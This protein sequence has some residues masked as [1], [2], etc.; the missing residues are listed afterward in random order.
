MQEESAQIQATTVADPSIDPLVQQELDDLASRISEKVLP[1]ELRFKIERML[2]HLRRAAHS[3][4]Y[5]EEYERTAKYIEWALAVPWQEKSEDVLDLERAK[6]VFEEHHYG[7]Q[8]IKDRI[9]EYMAILQ[10]QKQSVAAGKADSVRA[11]ILLLVGLVGTGKTTFA[12]SIAEA[13]GREIIRVPFGGMGSARDLRGQSRLHLEAEPGLVIKGL[14][15]AKTRNPVM[16]LDEIDRVSE[17]ARMD[18]MGVLV[19]LLD[20][21][22]NH[23]FTDHY[24]DF[25]VDLSEVLFI[26][27]ANNTRHIATAVYDRMEHLTM[28]SYT[29]E[30]K[31]HIARRYVMPKMLAEAGMNKDTIVFSDDVWMN[32][33]RPLGFDSGIRTLERTLK[34]VVAKS[35]RLML[36][37]G[38]DKVVITEENVR[39]FLPSY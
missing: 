11:P 37:Q 10:F 26:A 6:K 32:M 13:L 19:E 9:L 34:G 18:I 25:P 28:P 2:K 30:E 22:Q 38:L 16:L 14:T 31:I 35:A 12:Y 7:M 39:Y 3:S 8:E 20:P 17:D 1:E 29:D 15:Q 23:S 24:L 21:N 5:A 36:E 33:V 4:S 27:T